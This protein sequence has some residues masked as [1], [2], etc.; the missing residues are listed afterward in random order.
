VT[1]DVIEDVLPEVL[2]VL[3]DCTT[4]EALA[5]LCAALEIYTKKVEGLVKMIDTIR[6][7]FPQA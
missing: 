5:V 3:E 6:A 4:Q 7:K 2:E 1:R